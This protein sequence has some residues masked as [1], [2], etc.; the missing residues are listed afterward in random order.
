[1]TQTRKPATR[2]TKKRLQLS[3]QLNATA[4]MSATQLARRWSVSLPAIY[5]LI[6]RAEIASLKIGVRSVR[7]PLSAIEKYELEHTVGEAL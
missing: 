4:H 5:R 2:D 6:E 1:M 3:N 7:I